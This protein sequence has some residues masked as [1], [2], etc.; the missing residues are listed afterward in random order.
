MVRRT[1]L[2]SALLPLL[3]VE[4]SLSAG[5]QI[6][7]H[8]VV[9]MGRGFAGFGVN[10]DDASSLH[11]N[12]AGMSLLG[13]Q[14]QFGLS[15]INSQSLYEDIG[16]TQRVF[17]GVGFST[18]PGQGNDDD[19]GVSAVIPNTYLVYPYND[20][21]TFGVGIASPFGLAT[22]YDSGWVG[23]YHGIES[24]LKTVDINP[25]VSWQAS[26]SLSVGFGV[27][28]Q[29]AEVVLSRAVYLAPLSL[30]DG[31]VELEGNDWSFGWN[32]GILWQPTVSQRLGISYRSPVKHTIKGERDL[33]APAGASP[34]QAAAIGAGKIDAQSELELPESVYVGYWHQ[35]NPEWALSLGARWTRWSRF[36]ELRISFPGSSNAD[37]VTPE[38]WHNV[39]MANIGLDYR[40]NDRWTF[41]GGI[42][43]DQSP[44]PNRELRTVRVPDNDRIWYTLG[45]SYTPS[46]QWRWDVAYARLEFKGAELATE[47]DLFS[48]SPGAFTETLNGNYDDASADIVGVQLQYW[49]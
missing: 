38:Q 35:L 1:W 30:A 14:A 11:F 7:E 46:S 13:E 4:S 40:W 26:E 9:G 41:R 28:A 44:V 37:D 17:N 2:V 42:A 6:T 25:S 47:I 29:Y 23:R 16:T 20:S 34:A 18:I 8:S 45:F 31:F 49:F 43:Y 12:P 19:G 3:Y 15:A 39:W 5:F 22:E 10:H 21:I 36:D 33:Q 24:S 32:A 27:S 48:A